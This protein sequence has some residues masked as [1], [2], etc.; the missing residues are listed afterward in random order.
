MSFE[1]R[2]AEFSADSRVLSI[3]TCEMSDILHG[4]PEHWTVRYRVFKMA[5]DYGGA[6]LAAPIIIVFSLFIFV[7]NPFFNRG[8]LLFW[9]TR[10][11]QN[12]VPFRMVKFRTM[13]CAAY[14]VR[15]HDASVEHHR[16]TRFGQWMRKMRIDELPNFYD[17][18][19]G[20]MSLVGPRPDA[21][22]HA[23]TFTKELVGYKQRHRVKPGI[24]GLA[25]VEMGYAEG[26]AATALKA[27][28][29][30]LYAARSCGKLDIYILLKTVRVVLTGFG[31]K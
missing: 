17:V 27:K 8:P 25:Q 13:S 10:M 3:D 5:V 15:A 24:T 16:I 23:E 26:S 2:L 18:L 12:G 11:G 6:L 14:E 1:S 21:L 22:S 30:N 4:G 7:L 28:Y 19:R 20:Q 31:S 29:D 9:Q